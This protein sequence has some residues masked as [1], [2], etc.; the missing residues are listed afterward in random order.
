MR[1]AWSVLLGACVSL[2]AS[3]SSECNGGTIFVAAQFSGGALDATSLEVETRTSA[4]YKTAA[5][6]HTPGAPTGEVEIT[7][8]SGYPHG[9]TVDVT[10]RALGM[11]GEQLG[12]DRQTVTL[13]AS[14]RRVSMDLGRR[15]VD[16]RVEQAVR[17]KVDL[18]FVIDDSPSMAPKQ[19]ELKARFPEF[20]KAIDRLGSGGSKVSYHIG[21]ITTDVGAGPF[22][23]GSGQCAPGGRGG[24]LQPKGAA[25]DVGCL[26][27]LGGLNFIELNQIA[28]TSNL[29][30]GQDLAKTFSCMASVGDK[31]CGFEQPLESVYRALHD[32]PPENA[33]FL[34]D[35]ALLVVVFVTDEDDCS[36]DPSS[37]LFDPAKT[38]QYGSLL[39]YRCSQYGVM[40]GGQLLPY[41]GSGGP[42]TA[43]TAATPAAGGKLTDLNKYINLFTKPAASGGVKVNPSDVTLVGI[44]GPSAPVSSLLAN[45]ASTPYTSC[46][47]PISPTCAVVLQHACIS[48]QNISFF[49]DPAVR[50][51]QLI[52]SVKSKQVT[53][54]CD[55]SYQSAVEG[56]G[57]LV[58]A[59]LVGGCIGG[60]LESTT[61][62]D[63]QVEDVAQ[64]ADGSIT[65]YP[66]PFCGSNDGRVPCWRVESSASCRIGSPL[67][68]K[69][70]RG[71]GGLPPPNISARASC[72]VL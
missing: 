13:D 64:S 5:V 55:T 9:E 35:D 36:V 30:T 52:N 67:V 71:A 43:C 34:R 37:D 38:G 48:P 16:V 3:C 50:L 59:N 44:T 2:S 45:P 25:A 29:P 41:A 66:V 72:K 19:V 23:L 62:P 32:R 51:N 1:A 14:C 63:C 69:I 56:L 15:L 28:N 24:K 61:M 31:G 26:A 60:T 47:G 68:L 65:I 46:P 20:V 58:G 21:V 22:T 42:L 49:G 27:P 54:V 57:L 8:P 70:D 6:A 17:N 39:S 4:G 12:A 7:F 33:N 53:S 11:T 10:L 18:L 40:C